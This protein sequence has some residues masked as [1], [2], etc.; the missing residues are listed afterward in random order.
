[1]VLGPF[2]VCGSGAG[3]AAQA[4]AKHGAA[5]TPETGESLRLTRD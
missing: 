3:Q 1:M 4:G 5:S 2:G